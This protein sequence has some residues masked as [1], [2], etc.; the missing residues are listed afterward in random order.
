MS[1]LWFQIDHL[2][3]FGKMEG[4]S[5]ILSYEPYTAAQHG[6]CT[7]EGR[8]HR[9]SQVRLRA[10]STGIL[11]SELPGYSKLPKLNKNPRILFSRSPEYLNSMRM[12]EVCFWGWFLFSSESVKSEQLGL[13]IWLRENWSCFIHTFLSFSFPF[14]LPSFICLSI[15]LSVYPSTHSSIYL[16]IHHP[17]HL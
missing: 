5:R 10:L 3:A 8:G 2:F 16:S 1:L 7:R 14:F 4:L 15:C 12:K 13:Q 9:C 17:S 6:Y 11:G